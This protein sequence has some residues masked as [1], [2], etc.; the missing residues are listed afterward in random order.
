MPPQPQPGQYERPHP[1]QYQSAQYQPAPYQPA[2]YQPAQYQSGPYHPAQP[3]RDQYQSAQYPLP[4]GYERDGQ[5]GQYGAPMR[6]E[7]PMQYDQYQ[8]GPG[9]PSR[10]S[11][12]PDPDPRERAAHYAT[13]ADQDASYTRPRPPGARDQ[14][15]PQDETDPLNIA[16]LN[17][18]NYT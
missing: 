14:F 11:G 8:R 9:G 18:G 2:P 13:F 10:Q 3:Q 5:P 7:E 15:G 17:T 1:A 16:P 6:Y 4:P 12:R